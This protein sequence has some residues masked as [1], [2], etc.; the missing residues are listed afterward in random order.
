MDI[1]YNIV[2][3]AKKLWE[4]NKLVSQPGMIYRKISTKGAHMNQY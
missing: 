4:E 2:L 3:K 1:E